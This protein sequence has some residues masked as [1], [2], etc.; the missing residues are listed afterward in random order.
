M[1]NVAPL[2]LGELLEIRYNVMRRP[3]G[4]GQRAY[5]TGNTVSIY[6]INLSRVLLFRPFYFD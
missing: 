2:K 5:S 4:D 6:L 1:T 3:F